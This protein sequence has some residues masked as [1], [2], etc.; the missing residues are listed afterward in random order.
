MPTTVSPL[1]YPGGKTV[2]ADMITE[3]ISLNNLQGRT[4][5]EAFAG[6]AGAALT[7]LLRGDVPAIILND[8]DFAIYSFWH[9]I[10]NETEAFLRLL[11]DTPISVDE[12]H[13][14][15]NIYRTEHDNQLALGFATF[16]LNRC[17]RAGILAANPIGGL[18]Q[19]GT[20]R[21]NARFNKQRLMQKIQAIADHRDAIAI[22]NH[23]AVDFIA[24][25]NEEYQPEELFIYFD[26]PYY[27]K[28]ELLYLNHF[29]HA[30]HL[31]LR[32]HIQDIA[33]AWILS[34]D[35][36][37]E[38]REM[39]NHIPTYER[40]LRYSIGIPS[41]GNELIISPLVLPEYLKCTD[42]SHD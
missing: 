41:K 4:F 22:S 26:P 38:I 7:L 40:A 15:R 23:N 14:Q 18:H 37:N 5:V 10:L 42:I 27:K 13:N 29:G 6:G 12:W 36:E 3:V 24:H 1:R 9:S 19:T 30:Q 11:N 32:D 17:N 8:Y 34:Y 20:Y 39:Y 33:F 31:D 28:G 2:Y 21:I 25:L 16:Y 35:D